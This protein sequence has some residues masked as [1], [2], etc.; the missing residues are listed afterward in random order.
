MGCYK[1]FG[2][3]GEQPRYFD[4]NGRCVSGRTDDGIWLGG[5]YTSN[6]ALEDIKKWSRGD[7]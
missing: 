1:E 6:E 4:E 5:R 7:E 3:Y 2:P